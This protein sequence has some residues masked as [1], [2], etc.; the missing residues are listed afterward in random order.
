MFYNDD[1]EYFESK[2][3]QKTGCEMVRWSTFNS[4]KV[5]R[6]LV[7]YTDLENKKQEISVS[8]DA[9][10]EKYISVFFVYD[11][12]FEIH[13]P[14]Q[15]VLKFV[16]DEALYII[17][18]ELKDIIRE[19][20]LIYFTIKSPPQIER[21][22]QREYYRLNLT[23]NIIILANNKNSTD[24]MSMSLAKIIN[25]SAA[26]VK[27]GNV[28]PLFRNDNFYDYEANN[29]RLSMYNEFH[30]ILIL[31]S[32]ILV[33]LK[34]NFVRYEK[35]KDGKSFYCFKFEGKKAKD[36]DTISKFIILEQ[37]NQKKL[38]QEA[39]EIYKKEINK[40]RK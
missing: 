9:I 21:R 36:I 16:T 38:E 29:I 6:I 33:R 35:S 18:T 40:K 28:E 32:K 10:G 37:V 14:Q 15:I 17:E 8:K 39:K 7:T 5:K 3:K 30:L 19:K 27:I 31:N 11:D 12:N 1:N 24:M 4:A 25:L 23:K 2:Y 26:G 22:Q 13:Y 34:A 20:N